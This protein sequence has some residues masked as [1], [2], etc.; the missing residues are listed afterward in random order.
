MKKN[1]YIYILVVAI[2]SLVACSPDS[3]DEGSM[4]DK[5]TLAFDISHSASNANVVVYE[6]KT[7]GYNV[8]WT[9][10]NE[11]KGAGGNSTKAS[12][13]VHF[14]FPGKYIFDYSIMSKAGIVTAEP[15]TI[16]IVDYDL[17]YM[18]N[19]LWT[20]LTGGIGED[21]VWYLDLDASGK[22][23]YWSGPMYFYGVDD[24]WESVT[25][26]K[27][28]EGDSWNWCPDWASNQW[29]MPAANYGSFTFGAVVGHTLHADK[30]VEEITDNGTYMMDVDTHIMTFTKAT[31]LR[32]AN[33]I[34]IVTN[35]TKVKILSLTK[36]AMQLG[37]IRD[38][39][40]NEGPAQLVYNYVSK[41]YYDAHK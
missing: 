9:W 13:Q 22:S 37:V 18:D 12:S 2:L 4:P 10:D 8:Y 6:S 16:E 19:L 21:K 14:G 40:P 3:Y 26:G 30:K 11:A 24:S 29:L 17:A 27:E 38:N 31:M 5:S 39:D 33:R 23:V 20:Y 15:K 28:V 35:W 25:E 41:E 34:P 1:T 32:D 36:D 7:Q